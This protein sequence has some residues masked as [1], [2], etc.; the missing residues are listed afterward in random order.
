VLIEGDSW[1]IVSPVSIS[2]ASEIY[3][4]TPIIAQSNGCLKD[5][6]AKAFS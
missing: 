6:K 1:L 5:A 4:R 2:D 3:S